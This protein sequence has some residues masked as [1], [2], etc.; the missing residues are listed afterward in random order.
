[1]PVA[2]IKSGQSELLSGT[3][4]DVETD[5]S[6][7]LFAFSVVGLP[8][9]AVEE[10][11]D[12]VNSAIKNSGFDSPKAT[13]QKVVISLAPADIKKEGSH[14]DLP[15]AISYLLASEQLDFQTSKKLFL[16][17]L[18]L[19]GGLRKISGV[20]PIVKKA[21]EEGF[22]EVFVPK[23]NEKEARLIKDI[24]IIPVQNLEEVIKILKDPKN[25]KENSFEHNFDT[26]E[27]TPE[28]DFADIK[29]HESAKRSLTIAA[30]G[31]HNVL[32]WGPPGT[33]KTM[34]AKAL[35]SILPP[36]SYEDIIEAT[37][38]HSVCGILNDDFIKT[39][40]FRAP[41]HTSSH[42]AIVGGGAHLRPG[43]I[44]L[45]H[46]GLLFL[47]EFPE[48][49]RRVIESLREPLEERKIRI[50][51]A[52]GTAIFP[53]DFILVTAMNPCPCGNFGTKKSCD[54][55]PLTVLKY[56]R[57]I[58][59]PII[60]RIDMNIEIGEVE[61]KTLSS[62]EK[63]ES[64]KIVREKVSRTREKQLARF[65]K[66]SLPYKLNKEIKAKHIFEASLITESA[67]NLLNDI[68]LKLSISP[69][70]YHRIIRLARTI[71]D[72]EEKEN[73]E[74]S[75]ILEAIQYRQKKENL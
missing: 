21:K 26:E 28:I 69:R 56:Q 35:A 2:K 22:L 46:K 5:L 40:P 39:P 65:K 34:L 48:F 15:I 41:H 47:D 14:F 27:T 60:D 62:K 19:D 50:A 29:G 67:K 23:D 33:G 32:M 9:K 57:K 70:S 55:P 59:G 12:R 51:R 20:L 68:A 30:S 13:N 17:E 75:H 72:L 36:L 53:A 45:A 43:E 42:V 66:L 49:D 11:K 44:T 61:H 74:N 18:A 64:S 3:I 38:I 58:S 71:A 24:K 6:R 10:A 54:C 52:K 7:G 8:D 25:Y 63:S 73:V 16:G 4:I 1:M 37:S 31:G